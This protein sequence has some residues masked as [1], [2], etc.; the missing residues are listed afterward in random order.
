MKRHQRVRCDYA[1]F[2]LRGLEGS[3]MKLN[4]ITRGA[5]Q[6]GEFVHWVDAC[7]LPSGHEG[8]HV[9]PTMPQVTR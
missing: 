3:W 5:I 4:R 7:V 2:N 1:F 8:D 9:L 6:R